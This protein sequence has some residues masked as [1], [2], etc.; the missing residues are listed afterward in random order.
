MH[1]AG[2]IGEQSYS[3]KSAMMR[4]TEHGKMGEGGGKRMEMNTRTREFKGMNVM[5]KAQADKEGQ[6]E[7]SGINRVDAMVW[8]KIGSRV[9]RV[10][11]F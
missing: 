2:G 8:T 7:L 6:R 4:F 1:I 10:G 5:C 9:E 3:M 11:M